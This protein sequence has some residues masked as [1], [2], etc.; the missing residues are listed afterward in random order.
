MEVRPA[1]SKDYVSPLAESKK[2]LSIDFE[3]QADKPYK[4]TAGAIEQEVDNTCKSPIVKPFKQ[5][6]QL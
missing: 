1:S 2:S 4:E 6:K 5:G 3:S